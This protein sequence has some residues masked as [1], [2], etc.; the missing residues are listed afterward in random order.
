[1]VRIVFLAM[2]G[3]S[4]SVWGASLRSLREASKGSQPSPLDANKG[5]QLSPRF[6]ASDSTGQM[7]GGGSGLSQASR[8]SAGQAGTDGGGNAGGGFANDGGQRGYEQTS[9]CH[10]KCGWTCGSQQC[11]EVCE[12][13]CAPPQCETACAAINVGT[14]Q[15]ICEPPKCAVVCP[16]IHCEHGD[17][18]RCKTICGPPV[19]HTD[20]AE[21][22]E[23]KCADPQCSWKCKPGPECTQPSCALSCS[24]AK[25][26]NF[27]SDVGA[28]P[29]AVF[30][31][32]MVT[33]S[34]SL[35][36]L[37]PSSLAAQAAQPVNPPTPAPLAPAPPPPA[38]VA[39]TSPPTAEPST[40]IGIIPGRTNGAIGSVS[41]T[42]A[43]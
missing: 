34:K 39:T 27:N 28:R 7:I 42:S 6:F 2:F 15:Q 24:S 4:A 9:D 18:P 21:Q 26:C 17:C 8:D 36:A 41:A 1:M 38:P 33:V 40:P 32:G 35:A 30:N 12:P 13:V 16:T 31:P 22:C 3:L 29:Q 19:C 10:P 23:S 14:C 11:D 25:I 20:C 5:V 43:R 37:D